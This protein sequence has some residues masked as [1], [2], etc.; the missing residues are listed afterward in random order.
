MKSVLL[1]SI[2]VVAV[3]AKKIP[4]ETVKK[5]EETIGDLKMKCI[6]ESKVDPKRIE[7][8]IKELDF[9]EDKALKCYWRCLHEK[10][11]IFKAD[12]SYDNELIV[13]KFPFIKKD[14]QE[15]CE[16]RHR[17]EKDNCDKAFK[18]SLCIIDDLIVEK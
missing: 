11:N 13:K 10:V 2:L 6:E 8:M 5:F 14:L 7:K 15:K 16:K 1:L 9:T 18:Y 12:G 4:E 3:A 17:D